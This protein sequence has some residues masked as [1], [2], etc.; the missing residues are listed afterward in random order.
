MW[1][2]LKS[3]PFSASAEMHRWPSTG[4]FWQNS[5]PFI[6]E[7]CFNLRNTLDSINFYPGVEKADDTEYKWLLYLPFAPLCC[8][9]SL[10]EHRHSPYI[11]EWC[12]KKWLFCPR[13]LLCLGVR[14]SPISYSFSACSLWPLV[15]GSSGT[16]AGL[17]TGLGFWDSC[18]LLAPH[19]PAPLLYVPSGF[20]LHYSVPFRLQ[21]HIKSNQNAAEVR[22]RAMQQTA[23]QCLPQTSCTVCK[24][25]WVV[26]T[27]VHLAPA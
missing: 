1:F 11:W 7:K 3:F 14:S 19:P 17:C 5:G 25:V 8:S 24:R 6:N 21:T 10:I 26:G 20:D 22:V 4:S 12:R 16:W 18:A 13:A 23:H 27:S 9:R 15:E 2:R